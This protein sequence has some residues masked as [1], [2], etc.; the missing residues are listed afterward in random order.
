M[1]LGRWEELSRQLVSSRMCRDHER[2]SARQPESRVGRIPSVSSAA[3][4]FCH[5]SVENRQF[6]GKL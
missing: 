2:G 5:L 3:M 4:R 6:G 1:A